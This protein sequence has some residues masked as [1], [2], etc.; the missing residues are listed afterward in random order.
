MK[1]NI[2]PSIQHAYATMHRNAQRLLSLINEL[3]DF[4]KLES[5]ALKLTVMKGNLNSFLQEIADE[6]SEWAEQKEINFSLNLDPPGFSPAVKTVSADGTL[7]VHSRQATWFDRQVLEKIV[8][9]LLHN[10]FK[11]TKKGGQ[12]SLEILPSL[13]AFKPSYANELIPEK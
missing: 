12:I 2:R 1:E 10:S 9:N 7:S 5:G 11:Y 13:S 4:G 3:M 8:L 6:F